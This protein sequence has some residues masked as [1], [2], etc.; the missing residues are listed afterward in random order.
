M[1]LMMCI[2]RLV[3]VSKSVQLALFQQRY[4][5]H[6]DQ[7]NNELCTRR[8]INDNTHAFVMSGGTRDAVKA[9][10]NQHRRTATCPSVVWH[11]SDSYA[12]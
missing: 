4:S 9:M 2:A 12:G 10:A 11:R 3:S 1:I 5:K 7:V 8:A 6:M